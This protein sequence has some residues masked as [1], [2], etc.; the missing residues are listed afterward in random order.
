MEAK[1]QLEVVYTTQRAAVYHAALS[2]LKNTAAAE[3]VMQD[4]FL[5]YYHSLCEGKPVRHVRAWLLTVTRR[6]C[7]NL[8][9]DSHPEEL[10]DDLTALTAPLS[11]LSE[12]LA[13]A[14]RWRH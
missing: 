5:A 8:L 11:D 14:K 6:R 12:Q 10:T 4:V 2:F 9:R 3:D 7:L 1:R 13:S